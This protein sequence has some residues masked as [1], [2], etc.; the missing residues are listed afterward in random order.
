MRSFGELNPSQPLEGVHSSHSDTVEII[1]D[2]SSSRV[3]LSSTRKKAEMLAEVPR[4]ISFDGQAPRG[5]WLVAETRAPRSAGSIVLPLMEI[6]VAHF[7]QEAR[8]MF[9]R[10]MLRS[11]FSATKC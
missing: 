11:L 10:K 8:P 4:H 6:R 3:A 9:F 7:V 1:R 5:V 2:S